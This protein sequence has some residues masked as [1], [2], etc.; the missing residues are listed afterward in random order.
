MGRTRGMERPVTT[1]GAVVASAVNRTIVKPKAGE[2]VDGIETWQSD[3]Y[4][5][6]RTIPEYRAAVNWIGNV[7]SKATLFATED[8]GQGLKQVENGTL[9]DQAMESFFGG[10]QGQPQMLRSYAVHYTISGEC[11]LVGYV[12]EG[13]A[14]DDYVWLM[15]APGKL[16][17]RGSGDGVTY[18]IG[19]SSKPLRKPIVIRSWRP[20]PLDPQKADSPSRAALSALYEIDLATQ[21]IQADL[22]SRLTS[23]GIMFVAEEAVLSA[24]VEQA[25][26]GTNEIRTNAQRW[27]D[28]LQQIAET[29]IAQPGTAAALVPIVATVPAEFVDKAHLLKFWSDL[30]ENAP[31]MRADAVRRM[32]LG[33]DMPPEIVTGTGD[34]N[35]WGQWQIE[36][37]AVKSHTEPLLAQI[38]ADIAVGYLRPALDDLVPLPRKFG[39]GADTSAM[40]LRPN[41]SQEALELNDRGILK[42]S[43]TARETGFEESDMMTGPERAQW[44]LR[45]TAQGSTTPEIVAEALRL[46]G[47]PMPEIAVPEAIPTEERPTPSLEDHPR[48]DPPEEPTAALLAAAEQMVFRALERAGNRIK[49]RTNGAVPKDVAAPELYLYVPCDAASTTF[50]MEDAWSHV[51]RFAGSLGVDGVRLAET[52]DSYCKV[53]LTERKPHDPDLLRSYLRLTVRA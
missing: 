33:M 38:S 46:M 5:F 24:S 25:A 31:K 39:V 42:D 2:T 26:D 48:L 16:R 51:D 7:A 10:A 29:A 41:R 47:V 43:A 19:N 14:D 23:A 22:T 4:R 50:V 34:V 20:D 53:L 21:H 32:A 3:C 27:L 18:Y 11:W 15:L 13:N 52:L 17:S 45:K 40:R 49:N 35:H 9:A 36:E 37:S 28:A 6:Y 1:T 44:L 12:P 8:T 30:D